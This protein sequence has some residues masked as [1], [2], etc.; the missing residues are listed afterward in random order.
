MRGSQLLC[1]VMSCHLLHYRP[2]CA[3]LFSVLLIYG[4][5]WRPLSL[6]LSRSLTSTPAAAAFRLILAYESSHPQFS[7][8]IVFFL[9]IF[10]P[11]LFLCYCFCHTTR[12]H[13]CMC[14]GVRSGVEQT[15]LH[16]FVLLFVSFFC[17]CI[18]PY[19]IPEH[20]STYP[21]VPYEACEM[22]DG[23]ATPDQRLRLSLR[24][25]FHPIPYD[26]LYPAGYFGVYI[27]A[28][29]SLM[30]LHVLPESP[31]FMLLHPKKFPKAQV[32]DALK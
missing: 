16:L 20:T 27:M 11:M 13:C 10:A 3:L 24:Y 1:H 28:G 17:R 8:A 6:S 21:P 12:L 15:F 14:K 4:N 23:R 32:L 29:V 5:E 30:C 7:A 19:S 18:F 26:I 31:M 2:V 22:V 25:P 9:L